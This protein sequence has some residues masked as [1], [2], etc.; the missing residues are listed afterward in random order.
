MNNS[1]VLPTITRRRA[2]QVLGAGAVLA[3]TGSLVACGG[4]NNANQGAGNN[5]NQ[6]FSADTEV[7]DY[8][9][10]LTFCVDSDLATFPGKGTSTDQLHE[11][12]ANYQAQEGRSQVSISFEYAATANIAALAAGEGFSGYD[13][14]ITSLPIMNTAI[15]NNLVDAGEG[16]YQLRTFP[17]IFAT[18]THVVCA[19]GSGLTLPAAATLDGNDASDGSATRFQKINEIPGYLAI[20]DAAFETVGVSANKLLNGVGLYSSS[21]GVGG[22]YDASI[23]NKIK[24]YATQDEAMAAVA[25]GECLFGFAFSQGLAGRYP[26]VEDCYTPAGANNISYVGAPVVDGSEPGVVRDFFQY[27]SMLS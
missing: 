3:A 18:Q 27:L 1:N 24:T 11:A 22:E 2:C 16:N 5:V 21:E 20:A 19:K 4:A 9:V 12:L 6:G 23:A 15:G 25:T 17:L 14:L 10:A 7:K 8:A 26:Q 13:G